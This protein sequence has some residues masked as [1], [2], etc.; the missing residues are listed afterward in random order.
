[1]RSTLIVLL[2][3]ATAIAKPLPK[4]MKIA[5][6]GDHVMLAQNGV[7]IRLPIHQNHVTKLTKAELSDDGKSIVVEVEDCIEEG[8]EVTIALAPVQAQIENI[9]GM[10]FHTKKK[11]ADAITHFT[12]AVAADPDN[13]LYVTNLLSAQ[14]MSNKLTD[15]DDTLAKYGKKFAPWIAWRLDV[16]PELKSLVGRASAKLDAPKKGKATSK[17]E[18]KIAYSP[19]GFAATE[20]MTD[21][22]V[23]GM[24]GGAN[25]ELAIVSLATGKEVLRLPTESTCSVDPMSGEP[26][27]KACAKR[28]KVRAAKQRKVAD[29]LLARLGFDPL[30]DDLSSDDD[31]TAKDGRAYHGGD[32]PT[33]THGKKTVTFHPR[34]GIH[35][36]AF[37]PGALVYVVEDR[38]VH[39]CS[40]SSLTGHRILF[41]TPTP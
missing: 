33:L 28:E 36:A 13:A 25:Y 17:L 27:D 1:M 2:L 41:A 34:F 30:A 21:I 20:V 11:Y 38:T 35:S 10:G 24:G 14:A 19:L 3:S 31:I 5:V 32:P 15:A 16:D 22:D 9:T 6:D 12:A 29:D 18:D 26:D 40:G 39:D 37:V 4:G 8:G 23:H 7:T